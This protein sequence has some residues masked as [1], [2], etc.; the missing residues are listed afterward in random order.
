MVY[1]KKWKWRW[2][3]G[4]GFHVAFLFFDRAMTGCCSALL[5]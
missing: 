1:R 4:E 2:K 3:Q 5:D